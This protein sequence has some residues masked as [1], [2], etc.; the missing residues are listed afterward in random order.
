MKNQRSHYIVADFALHQAMSSYTL[1]PATSDDFDVSIATD[2]SIVNE[3]TATTI[4]LV[5]VVKVSG[6]LSIVGSTWI[7]QSVL[8]NRRKRRMMY[9]RLLLA[10]S[11]SDICCSSWMFI[12]SWA[13][14][15]GTDGVYMALGNDLTCRIQGFFIQFSIMT[16][17][18]NLCLSIYYILFIKYSWKEA[19]LKKIEP[20]FYGA[21]LCWGLGSALT[22]FITKTYASANLYCWYS[23]TQTTFR[24]GFFYGPMWMCL[25]L[26]IY[27]MV[28]IYLH[29]RK[30]ERSIEKYEF[31]AMAEATAEA[32]REAKAETNST[33][34]I[35]SQQAKKEMEKYRMRRSR[36]VAIQSFY[37]VGAAI[38]AYLFS[39]VTR[40]IQLFGGKTPY[41]ILLLMAI[42][43]PLQ[44]FMNFYVY[45]RPRFEKN[46][47]N[48]VSFRYTSGRGKSDSP[49]NNSGAPAIADDG[50]SKK[51]GEQ[52]KSDDVEKRMELMYKE[53]KANDETNKT[54]SRSPV[55]SSATAILAQSKSV[56]SEEEKTGKDTVDRFSGDIENMFSDSISVSGERSAVILFDT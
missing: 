16:P 55:S 13:I 7:A 38:L 40:L 25:V 8:R 6:A 19:K 10:F 5:F 44:G 53:T 37:Y 15:V 4:S 3:A 32:K 51:I 35:F 31:E 23:S 1:S 34:D 27:I 14:P 49:S 22:G 2:A 33:H 28:N 52:V 48:S 54:E 47:R 29:I 36:Q 41:P 45:I 43:T 50:N 21:A 42:F 17:I 18:L 24:Y 46:L 20:L 12:G 39:A 11:L 9:H 56:A 26:M 30:R